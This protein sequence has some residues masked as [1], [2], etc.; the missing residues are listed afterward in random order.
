LNLYTGV[1][2]IPEG[3]YCQVECPEHYVPY[4]VNPMYYRSGTF[5]DRHCECDVRRG[6]CRFQRT[7]L[8]IPQ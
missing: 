5:I 4:N 7:E 2:K 1:D 3:G 6:Y 8:K